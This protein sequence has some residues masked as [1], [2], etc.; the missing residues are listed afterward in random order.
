MAV[1][2]GSV[3]GGGHTLRMTKIV[4][5][6]A[7]DRLAQIQA[8]V[9]TRPQAVEN[10]LPAC[11]V[12]W[13]AR[14]GRWRTLHRGVYSIYT[15]QPAR[16]AVLWAAVLRAGRGAA[17]SFET[18]A[19]VHRLV[20]VPSFRVHVSIP[21]ERTM[22]PVRGL[23]VHR[24]A[25]LA[26]AT[27]PADLPPR[28]RIEETVLDLAGQATSF[29][30][31]FAIACAACQR[32]LT[33]PAR[34]RR[35]ID[36]RP[37]LRWRRQLTAALADIGTGVHSL[38]E[39]RYVRYVERPH[40]L[41]AAIR[42]AKV[43]TGTQ[44]RYLDNLYGDFGVCVE[45]D[46]RQAHPDDRRWLDVKRDNATAARGG[47]TLRYGWADIETRAC[48]TA[49]QVGLTLRSRGWTGCLRPCGPR[50]PATRNPRT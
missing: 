49:I 23:V 36:A 13:L 21:S 24:S 7:C 29:D 41:P 45:L 46:G 27:H 22:L 47:V 18:A 17:L 14:T 5:P 8:G 10:G 19:E 6:E 39:Y 44:A 9:I 35:A 50:C 4:L 11:S 3:R 32:R 30:A 38:L 2:T 1:G 20:D 48:E 34:L 33:T 37:K 26:R 31:A 43:V 42:Q 12:E 40:G 15:G 25:A 28:T 16:E